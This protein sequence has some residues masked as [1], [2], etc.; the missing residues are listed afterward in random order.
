MPGTIALTP[1]A[2]MQRFWFRPSK[3]IQYNEVMAVQSAQGGRITRVLG[4]NRVQISH[5][6]NHSAAAEFQQELERRTGK[7]VTN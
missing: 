7:R 6:S 3:Q 5:T 2:V 4:D 1:T